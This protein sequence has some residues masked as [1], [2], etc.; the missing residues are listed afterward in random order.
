MRPNPVLNSD[1][2]CIVFCSFSSSR[3]LGFAQ[4]FGAGGA[5]LAPFVRPLMSEFSSRILLAIEMV[6]ICLPL[7]VLFLVGVLPS[8]VYFSVTFPQP[9]AH[10]GLAG[11]LVIIATLTCSWRLAAAFV[12]RGRSALQRL[13]IYWWAFPFVSAFAAIG[14][15]LYFWSL[16]VIKPSWVNMFVSGAPCVIPLLHL[17]IERWFRT[18]TNEPSPA[19]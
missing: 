6:I 7:T 8:I 11:A 16:Q 17:C 1:P 10:V 14:A 13:S 9:D 12:F 5:R 4:R 19:A 3:F 15:S 18:S 2:A